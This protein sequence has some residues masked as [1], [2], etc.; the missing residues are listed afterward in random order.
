[1]LSGSE[2]CIERIKTFK[3]KRPKNR[4]AL[5]KSLLRFQLIKIK[6]YI[7]GKTDIIIT[8]IIKEVYQSMRV[9]SLEL[10]Y[11]FIRPQ[12]DFELQNVCG[13]MII[14]RQASGL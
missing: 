3:S 10:V 14:L 5:K 2:S 1:M 4:L 13:Y 8:F 7:W 6:K 9:F 12:S 11:K